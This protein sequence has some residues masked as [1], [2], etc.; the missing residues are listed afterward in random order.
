V[1]LP[2][3]LEE[4]CEQLGIR[5]A[6]I[7]LDATTGLGGHTAAIA[8]LLTTGWVIANDRD[9]E[10]LEMAKRN[11]AEFSSRIRF[12]HGEFST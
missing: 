8:R 10:S 7:Y 3:M 1:H 12:H 11:T 4:S 2:V 6:G 5:P 9:T